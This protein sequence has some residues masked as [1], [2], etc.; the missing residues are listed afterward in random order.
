MLGLTAHIPPWVLSVI[1]FPYNRQCHRSASP[2]V[3]AKPSSSTGFQDWSSAVP[4]G[5]TDLS[6]LA[7]I[8]CGNTVLPWIGLKLCW[9]KQGHSLCEQGH[10]LLCQRAT[11]LWCPIVRGCRKRVHNPHLKISHSRTAVII[12]K[13]VWEKA[14]LQGVL[15]YAYPIKFWMVEVTWLN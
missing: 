13:R 6:F 12:V 5:P 8:R 7:S 14:W 4:G 3:L 10:S 15:F 1:S 9:M 11:C 2:P